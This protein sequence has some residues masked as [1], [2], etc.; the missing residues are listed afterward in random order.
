VKATGTRIATEANNKSSWQKDAKRRAPWFC[1]GNL[2]Y[3]Y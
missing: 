3:W 2:Y 1:L